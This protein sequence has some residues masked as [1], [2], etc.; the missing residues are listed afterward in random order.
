MT[1][2]D[3]SQRITSGLYQHMPT[4]I[5]NLPHGWQ[6]DSLYWFTHTE[7]DARV[8]VNGIVFYK[9]SIAFIH[10][11]FTGL[12]VNELALAIIARK[13]ES[14]IHMLMS[15]CNDGIAVI[16]IE[17]AVYPIITAKC[18]NLDVVES[19]CKSMYDW[20]IEHVKKQ[21]HGVK[22]CSIRI[23]STVIGQRIVCTCDTCH[24]V[25]VAFS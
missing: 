15:D 20:M 3:V 13:L 9:F 16:V 2:P 23:S 11:I 21:K 1:D 7:T 6:G 8:C 10:V 17:K 25:F 22:A 18:L 5:H 24:E 12:I 14:L 19:C 4:V